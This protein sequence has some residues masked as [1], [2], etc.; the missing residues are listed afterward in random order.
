MFRF[1]STL[2][3]GTA[4]LTNVQANFICPNTGDGY[5]EDPEQCDLYWDCVDGVAQERLCPDG[6]VFDPTSRKEE[7]CDHY[8]IVQCNGRNL[9]QEPKGVSDECPRLNGFYSHPDPSVCNK[10]YSC[11]D[12]VAEEYTCSPGLWFDDY[13]GVCNWPEATE[14]TTC[15]SDH[16]VTDNG[17]K[18]P[19]LPLENAGL[20][21]DPHPK[22]ADP[23]DCAKFFICLNGVTPRAQGCELGLV[24]NT[25]TK[26]CDS[27]E[28]VPECKDYYAF[29]ED[30]KAA[31]LKAKQV[32][33]QQAGNLIN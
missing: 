4:A 14:R 7:P 22:Y 15:T 17:F 11:K 6:F 12:G 16:E 1:V 19:A 27:P 25:L 33:K 20:M 2:L 29:L 13:K 10:F 9:L 24:Y 3:V 8:F 30:D 32:V 26:Q 31:Q 23:E 28:N 21:S 18:C 5:Y